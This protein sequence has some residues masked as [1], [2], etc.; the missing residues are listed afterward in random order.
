MKKWALVSVFDKTGVVELCRDL[1]D[2]GYSLLST[3]GTARHLREAGLPVTD[4]E[5]YTEFPEMMDGRVKTLHP[6]IHGGLLAL[7][8]NPSHVE[9]MDKHGI[10][11]L[12]MVV[13]NLYPFSAT[14]ARPEATYEECVEMIDIGGPSM[15]RSAAKNHRFVIPLVD[16]ADYAEV[17][18]ALRADGLSMEHRK[19]LAAKVFAETAAYDAAIANYLQGPADD[20]EF[21]ASFQYYGVSRQPLRYGEN[22]HQV[23]HFYADADASAATIAGAKQLQGKELSYNNIQ[24]ADAA[25][26]ILRGF[27]D[28]ETPTAV[29]VKH[30]NPCGIGLGDTLLEAY[31]RAYEADEISIFGG[32]VAVNREV[33]GELATLLCQ[34]FLEIVISPH[35]NSQAREIF[36][37]KKNVRLLEVD[38]KAPLWNPLQKQFRRV[39]GGLLVQAVDDAVQSEWT[40]V[41][42]RQPSEEESRALQFAWRAVKYVKSNAIVIARDMQTIGIGPGQTNRVG[43][44]RIALAAAGAS[45]RGAVLASD[46]FFPM[47]DTVDAAAEAGIA[48]IVQPGGSIKDAESIAAANEHGIAM[49]FTGQRHFLH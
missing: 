14:V 5:S 46:A 44:A 6:R 24:D 34:L 18:T 15:L 38:M 27:D 40:V 42:M 49:V 3:G 39:T 9:S 43:A 37:K 22:P 36:S 30:M 4:V 13:V 16:P 29:A 23:A 48:A 28:F 35:F 8:D 20:M 7:R 2:L 26:Q 31:Q 47:R 17:I 1:S 45:A 11:S 25:L 41:T 19:K 32:I 10:E 12:E 21:P 33:D